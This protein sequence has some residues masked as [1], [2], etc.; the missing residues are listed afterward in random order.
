MRSATAATI[1]WSLLLAHYGNNFFIET[2]EFA[3][4]VMKHM[5]KERYG[6]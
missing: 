5:L 1:I 6:I 2:A 4:K 3:V